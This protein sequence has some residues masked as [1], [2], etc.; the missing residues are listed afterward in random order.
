MFEPRRGAGNGEKRRRGRE[1]DAKRPSRRT[2]AKIGKLGGKAGDVCLVRFECDE[3]CERRRGSFRLLTAQR[4]ACRGN[5]VIDPTLLRA[6]LDP[7]VGLSGRR[8]ARR[9]SLWW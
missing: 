4:R 8:D 9:G 1:P 6:E 2:A 5:A 7:L 3:L